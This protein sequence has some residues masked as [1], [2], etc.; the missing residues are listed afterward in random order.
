[1]AVWAV[2]LGLVAVCAAWFLLPFAWRK[3]EEGELAARCRDARAIVL[4]YDDGP[5]TMLTTG[6]L[7]LFAARGVK[8]SF[9]MLGDRV[10]AKPDIVQRL[11]ADGHDLGSHSQTHVN[12]WKSLPGAWARDVD[13]GMQTVSRAGG[14]AALFRPPYG[15]L[16]LAGWRAEKKRGTHLAWWTVDTRDSWQRRPIDDVLAEIG[17]KGGG[18]VLM[19]DFD[20]YGDG[21]EPVSHSEHVLALSERILDFAEERALR[22]MSLSQLEMARG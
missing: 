10:S 18:V 19:H 6:L 5:G 2:L 1:M 20:S 8:A 13:A 17:A 15:K 12:A 21:P 3:R 16:T 4:S 9:F 7:D 22:V 11:V 14:K